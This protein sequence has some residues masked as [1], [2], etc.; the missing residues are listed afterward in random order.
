LDVLELYEETERSTRDL[1]GFYRSV[2]D[3]VLTSFAEACIQHG[4]AY[5]IFE[6]DRPPILTDSE[7]RP[8]SYEGRDKQLRK[9]ARGRVRKFCSECER[10]RALLA[11][12]LNSEDVSLEH[13]NAYFF[14][15]DY[16]VP[17]LDENNVLKI[18]HLIL[19]IIPLSDTL[20][21]ECVSGSLAR[22]R[23]E[24]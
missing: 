11:P 16:R 19:G 7:G 4:C 2:L 1:T 5:I 10:I 22:D 17:S 9:A 24:E 12:R 14:D 18:E 3:E 23:Y 13:A 21:R 6:I 8:I 20:Q 15:F